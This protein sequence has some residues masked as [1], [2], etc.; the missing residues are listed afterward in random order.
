MAMD[1]TLQAV[2]AATGSFFAITVVFACLYIFW[3]G[4]KPKSSRSRYTRPVRNPPATALT[5]VA[6]DESFSFDPSLKVSMEEVVKATKNFSADLVVGDGGFGFVYKAQFSDGR[7]VAVKKLDPDAFQ[8]FREFQAEMETLGKLRHPNI[9]KILGYCVSGADRILIYEFIERGNLDRWLNDSSSSDGD[10]YDDGTGFRLPLSWKTRIKI[11][12]GVANGLAYLHGLDKPIIHRDIK[13]SNVLLDSEFEAHIADFGLAR[14]MDASRS[15]VSTQ[16]AGTMGYMPP[17]YKE[18]FTGATVRADVFS[19]GVLMLE[20]ATG[21]RPNLPTKFDGTEM[22]LVE[23]ARKMEAQNCQMEMVDPGISKDDL[24]EANVKEY[25]RI[26]CHCAG[27]ISR[28]RP[29]MKEVIEM[30]NQ[31]SI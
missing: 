31:I 28:E 26:A 10:G 7:T 25:F 24:D 12:R 17:E 20:V 21:K 18:G 1:K 15:H 29:P 11:V 14:R 13:A 30:L 4:S 16:F 6:V 19:F 3:K 27:E 9:V 5:S 22:G 8:G 23:W 2:L